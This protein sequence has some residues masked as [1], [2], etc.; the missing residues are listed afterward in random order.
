[1]R[2]ARR[3]RA[4]RVAVA[5]IAALGVAVVG[6]ARTQAATGDVPGGSVLR[7]SVPEAVG[8]KTVI[9]QLTVDHVTS[10]GFVTA[11]GCDDGLPTN[12]DGTSA[13]SDLNY[14]PQTSPVASNR[15]VV[16]ADDSGDV[17]FYTL[18]TVA[19]IVDVNA[20][21]FDT[22]VNSF[23]NRRVDTR[24]A[25]NPRV[26]AGGV[27]RV[28]V[29]EASGGKTVVGQLTVDRVTSAGYV[30]A[31]GCDD[32][33]PTDGTGISRSDLNFDAAASPVASNR[34]I[35]EADDHGDVCFYTLKAASIIVD[36]NGVSDVGITSFPNR[37]VDTRP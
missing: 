14:D 2:L 10:P 12:P 5:A 6:P 34:L 3:S 25:S 19:M 16:Q 33:I 18:K 30:T 28:A 27:F 23:P 4:G 15:L 9:G 7:I 11:Y 20:V 13:R 26:P 1:M 32:G 8:G 24:S 31:Y 17:C 21:T 35:V 22:G 29:P 37:R 36:V